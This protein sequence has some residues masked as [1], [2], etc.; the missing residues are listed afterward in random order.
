MRLN[1]MPWRER[2]RARDV[3]RFQVLLLASL[4]LALVVVMVLDQAAR[5]RLGRQIEAVAR[6]QVALEGLDNTAARIEQL[7]EARHVVVARHAELSR[8]RAGQELLPGLFL[9]LEQAL[10]DGAQLTG[11]TVE[12]DGLRLTGLAASASVVAQFMRDLQR[13]GI[14]QDLELIHLRHKA[15]GDEFLLAARLSASDS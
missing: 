12:G 5:A 15:R 3:R 13:V 2:R 1:L 4:V 6:Q 11:V 9:G 14:V 8:L 10:P 7:R